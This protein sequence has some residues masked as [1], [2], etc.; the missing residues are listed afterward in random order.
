VSPA[1]H[2]SSLGR[3][4]PSPGA[5]VPALLVASTTL[6][7]AH[8]ASA[9]PSAPTA[10]TCEERIPPGAVRP[11]VE[12]KLD[13][14]VAAG[15]AARL[16][17]T[18][19]HGRGEQVL[20][21]GFRIHPGT[22]L[23]TELARAGF[24]FADPSG[25]ARVEVS[26][27]LDGLGRR[28]RVS[29]PL[30][31]LPRRSGDRSLILPS[32]PIEV[33]RASGETM[34]LC[35]KMHL[36]TV[37]DP[38]TG[39][40]EPELRP[41]PPPR[42]QR[43]DWPLLR[44]ITIGVG[45]GLVLGLFVGLWLR[46]LWQKPVEADAP[47]GDLPW[48]EAL[49]ALDA[50]RSSPLLVEGRHGEHL[51]RTSD[52]LRRYLGERYGFGGVGATGLDRTTDEMLALLRRVTPPVV[53]LAQVRALLERAD[54]VKFAKLEI[55][56]GACIDA[57]DEAERI[58]RSTIPAATEPI[59]RE[60]APP[61]PPPAAPPSPPAEIVPAPGAPR[62][63][64]GAREASDLGASDPS[65]EAGAPGPAQASV[66]TRAEGATEVGP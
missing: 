60:G 20:P 10:V 42:P 13:G 34:T 22:K 29:I 38:T 17:L 26:S 25:V 53:G 57:L 62:E 21:G 63:A 6:V 24:A 48:I 47:V 64:G 65:G 46:R 56:R 2:A 49:R 30:V 4:R 27:E 31:V 5:L 50:L 11:T 32:V 7:A 43:E 44:W 8:G 66:E 59:A 12:E 40:D 54:L 1:P 33:A 41:N 55:D 37:R 14:E 18:L 45:T 28:T 16:E 19:S 58:V 15:R 36:V 52:I 61:A 35:T 23:A 39:T 3:S 51:D 9:Q